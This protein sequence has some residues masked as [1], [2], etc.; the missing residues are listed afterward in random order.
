MNTFNIGDE[1]HAEEIN[2][3]YDQDQPIG[4]SPQA[5]YAVGAEPI[6]TGNN[7]DDFIG[8]GK[9]GESL[10]K[11]GT[12]VKRATRGVD[13]KSRKHKQLQFVYVSKDG[14]DICKQYDGMIFDIDDEKR[15]V[16][17]RLESAGWSARPYTHP[18]CKCKWIKVKDS[19][20]VIDGV[21][22]QENIANE[23]DDKTIE[24]AKKFYGNDEEWEK[25]PS[26]QQKLIMI[27]MLQKSI[28]GEASPYGIQKMLDKFV[29][30]NFSK[31]DQQMVEELKEH[32]FTLQG[33]LEL[34][35][36]KL[37]SKLGKKL[38]VESVASE[39]HVNDYWREYNY[40]KK[41]LKEEGFK[42]TEDEILYHL[43]DMGIGASV[44]MDLAKNISKGYESAVEG[45]RGSG[46]IGHQ[47]WMLEGEALD[48]CPNCM[49]QTEKRD[50]KCILCNK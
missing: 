38:G 26:L 33:I 22:V 37:A 45:G 14:C 20:T 17:P 39:D 50:G 40:A 46:K 18:H 21:A 25:L 41:K 34:V 3:S 35:A 7:N 31:E 2:T 19:Y 1:E 42:G 4:D 28:G 8:A 15:P 11:D 32:D 9:L 5:Y 10:N 43:Q 27:K 23:I 44:A 48:E 29:A 47:P 49:I 16:I 30:K 6:N 24:R 13:P 12:G 36:D